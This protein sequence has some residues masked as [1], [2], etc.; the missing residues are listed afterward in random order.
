MHTNKNITPKM[1]K[2]ADDEN[3]IFSAAGQGFTDR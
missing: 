1:R 3:E 2:M